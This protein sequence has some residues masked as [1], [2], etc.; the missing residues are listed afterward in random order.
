MPPLQYTD[1]E[2]DITKS[3]TNRPLFHLNNTSIYPHRSYKYEQKNILDMQ[4]AATDKAVVK[5][6]SSPKQLKET[7]KTIP[8]THEM[9]WQ[10]HYNELRAYREQ[11]GHCRV[12]QKYNQNN[13]KLG[14]W[15]MQQRRQYRLRENGKKSSFDSSSGE[16]RIKLLD[17]LAFVWRARRR[18]PRGQYGEMRRMKA[19]LDA[20]SNNGVG[21]ENSKSNIIDFEKFMI[22]K[23]HVYSDEEVIESWKQRFEIFR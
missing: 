7:K 4:S 11:H 22:Q 13:L 14:Y 2:S 12:P 21:N 6:E 9:S 10:K 19:R 17:E 23:S 20:R 5:N 8:E 3:T 1:L 18:G 16:T 15:V